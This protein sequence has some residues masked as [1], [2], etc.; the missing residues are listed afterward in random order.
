MCLDDD[1]LN[2]RID[3]NGRLTATSASTKKYIGFY[4]KK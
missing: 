1:L 4:T 2:D 3:C